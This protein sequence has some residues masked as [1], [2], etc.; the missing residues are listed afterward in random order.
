MGQDIEMEARH[1]SET[2]RQ[3]RTEATY[4]AIKDDILKGRLAPES[5]LLEHELANRFGVSKTPIREAL[6]R[7]I[8]EGWVL[9]IPRRGYLVRPL[10]L[11]DVRE[12]WGLRQAIEPWLLVETSRRASTE[13]LNALLQWI[14][15]QRSA[16]DDRDRAVV[17][18]SNFH[19]SLAR[20]SGNG[21]AERILVGLFDEVRRLHHL[22]PRL[23]SRLSESQEFEDHL[24]IVDALKRRDP[25]EAADV[26]RSHLR[27]SLRQMV[28]VLTEL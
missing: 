12:V 10:R 14:D 3:S 2:S 23:D 8:S 27:E 5:L 7:L 4:H 9:V 16:A 17:S 1:P 26:M 22:Q 28:H 21:R 20:L 19:L 24:R 6:R 13:Q 25:E 11:E 18:G 15:A